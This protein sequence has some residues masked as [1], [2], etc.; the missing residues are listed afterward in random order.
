M[1]S[2]LPYNLTD[3]CNI[4]RAAEEA[5]GRTLSRGERRD[6]LMDNTRWT[7][8]EIRGLEMLIHERG[9]L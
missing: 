7:S 2:E 8:D 6:L 3:A 4:I 1:K 5:L 9:V